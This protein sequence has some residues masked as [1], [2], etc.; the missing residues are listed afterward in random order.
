MTFRPLLAATI[1]DLSEIQYPK[2]LSPKLDGIRCMIIGGQAVSRNL[3]PIRNRYVQAMLKG[4]PDGVD[5]ELIVG[6]STGEL[7]FNRTTSGVMSADGEPDFRFHVFDN[8]LFKDV[9]MMRFRSLQ[10]LRSDRIIMV[11]HMSIYDED[12]LLNTES[13]YLDAGYEGIML[14]SPTGYYKQGRSTINE[15]I[16]LKLKRFRDGEARVDGFEEGVHN[17]NEAVLDNL[18]LTHRS[19]HKD[20]KVGSKRIGTL[21]CTDLETNEPLVVSPGRMTVD[22]RIKYFNNPKLIEGKIIRYKT[23]DYGKVNASRFC[24]FQGFRDVNDL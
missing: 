18:G 17:L 23:F 12:A 19:M 21:L 10:M 13:M 8:F 2:M 16:L 6:S 9:F 1:E 15:Q 14:R 20:N 4:V 5:G 11:P 22:E 3:K 24:T 7:V